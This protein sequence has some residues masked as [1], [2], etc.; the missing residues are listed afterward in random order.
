MA[1]IQELKTWV[2]ELGEPFARALAVFVRECSNGGGAREPDSARLLLGD[3]QPFEDL[4][5]ALRRRLDEC[6]DKDEAAAKAGTLEM[7][8]FTADSPAQAAAKRL[9]KV[10]TQKGVSQK[11]L[12]EMLD[13]TPAVVSRVLKNP[14]R[15][16]VATLRRIA[17]TLG[18][19]LRE[20][21]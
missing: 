20:F 12:A 3:L 10:L 2:T 4:D 16:K 19:E 9:R 8:E 5:P 1:D 21:V 15:S 17:A 13:V 11:Q 18:V 6:V 7:I 14:D